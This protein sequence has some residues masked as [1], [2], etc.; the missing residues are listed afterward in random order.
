MQE[1]AG[2]TVLRSQPALF[3]DPDAPVPPLRPDLQIVPVQNNGRQLIL[4]HD[5]LGYTPNNFALDASAESLLYFINGKKSVRDIANQLNQQVKETDLLRFIQLLDQNSLLYSHSYLH[6]RETTENR[7]EKSKIRKPLLAGTAY[8]N[9][10]KLLNEFLRQSIRTSSALKRGRIHSLFAPHIDLSL[11]MEQ[12]AEAFSAISHMRPKRVV[13]LATAHYTGYFEEVYS[14]FPYIG[15][16]KDF[17][18]QDRLIRADQ[19]SL[20]QLMRRSPH[21]GFTLQDRAHRIEH[22]I[23]IHLLCLAAIWQ[24]SFSIVPILVGNLDEL[25]Y[26]TGGEAA[27]KSMIFADQIKEL[28]QPDTLFLISGDLSHTG[29]KFGDPVSARETRQRSELRDH[30]FLSHAAAGAP[31]KLLNEVASDYDAT[32]ICGFSPLYTYLKAFPGR[33]GEI[34]NYHWWDEQERESA[35]SFGSILYR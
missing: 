15:S 25:F 33:R 18:V 10:I 1:N 4:F 9:S 11:G 27:E 13:I 29:K 5:S 12:Y 14:G 22:S 23:E 20:K 34:L 26:H 21:N 28:D 32:H 6:A 8:Q 30:Q 16:A 19:A 2:G 35:V 3:S 7:F 24:H 31:V 17:Q